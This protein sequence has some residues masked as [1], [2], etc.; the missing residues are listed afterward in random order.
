[1]THSRR[2]GQLQPVASVLD[3][4]LP[5]LRLEERAATAEATEQWLAVASPEIARRT[6]AVGVRDGELL[7]EVR[8]STW[9]GHLAVLRHGIMNEINRRLPPE[10]HI[11]AIRLTPMRGKEVTES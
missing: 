5:G 7:V 10:A 4:M 9:M 1:M 2:G 3:Q 8:G 6:R 11:R